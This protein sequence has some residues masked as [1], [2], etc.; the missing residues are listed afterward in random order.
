MKHLLS[1]LLGITLLISGCRN[2]TSSEPQKTVPAGK[3]FS[4][5][6][7]TVQ[8][9]VVT[10]KPSS[11]AAGTKIILQVS[12]QAGY[13][14]IK[15]SLKVKSSTGEITLYGNVRTFILPSGNVTVTGNFE[16]LP[17]NT[18]SLSVAAGD[19]KHGAI[20][21]S[22]EYYAEGDKVFLAII[23]DEGYRY[24]PGSL[25][26]GGVVFNEVTR[27]LVMP[28]NNVTVDAD[29]EPVAAGNYTVRVDSTINGRIIANP[30]EGPEGTNIYLQVIASPGYVLKTGTLKYQGPGGD[31]IINESLSTATMP[32]GHIFISGEFEKL[33]ANTYSIGIE[34]LAHGRIF[35]E[36]KYGTAGSKIT[37]QIYPDQGYAFKPG[38]LK[39]QTST[40]VTEITGADRIFEMPGDNIM[41]L[42]EFVPANQDIVKVQAGNYNNGKITAVPDQGKKDT[43]I[44]L[45]IKPDAGYQLKPGSLQYVDST[46]HETAIGGNGVFL[47]P[48][49][50]VKIKAEFESIPADIYTIQSRETVNGHV[51]SM[52]G[53]GKE[54][55]PV[56]LWVMP[57][58]GYYYKKQTLKYKLVPSNVEFSISDET[59]TFKLNA[60]HVQVR[61]EFVKTPNGSFTIRTVPAEHGMIYPRQD[62]GNSGQRIEMVIRP[63]SG[64]QIKPGSLKYQDDN[65]NIVKFNGTE[66]G[67]Y[68]PRDHVSVSGEFEAIKYTINADTAMKDGSITIDPPQGTIGAL[69]KLK[70]TPKN[71]YRLTENSLKYRIVRNNTET[72]INEQTREFFMPPENILILAK[73]EPYSALGDLKINN[74]EVKGLAGG[75]TDYTIWIP[76]NENSAKI[77]FTTGKDITVSP[78]SGETVT[79][80]AL[81]KKQAV[82]TLNSQGGKLTT[83][84]TI[85]VIREFIPVKAV[86]GGSFQRENNVNNISLVSPFRMG[87]REVVQEEWN[88]VMGFPRGAEGKTYPAHHVS[89]Y[90]AVVFCNKLSMLEG[91]TPAYVIN[92]NT[93]PG[94]WGAI[95]TLTNNISWYVS[96]NWDVNGYR[97]PTEMEWHWAAMGADS[98]LAGV[99]NTSG[100]EQAFAGIVPNVSVGQAAWYKINSGG[101]IHPAGEKEAN[102]LGIRDMS[103]NVMEWCWDWVN[104]NYQKNYGL[105][106]KQN[107]YRGG[108][109]NTGNKMRRG[110]SYL[111]EETALVL[112]YRG[113]E[114]GAQ[115]A[116][117]TSGDPRTTDEYAGL[118]IVCYD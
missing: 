4:V 34:N 18:Y 40:G 102:A 52:P 73:F 115:T 31:Q 24:K 32:K 103:G 16:A 44:Y 46:G 62:Y 9:G 107:N 15:D 78:A 2:P 108:N 109:N 96:C 111:S 7:N 57:D 105:G 19:G 94:K 83:R 49:G 14:L 99:T 118:R 10:A 114:S 80:E 112:N 28:K 42:G 13:R 66:T 74:R 76:R 69:V 81:E 71:G 56:S 60:S 47:L 117:F 6:I 11:A 110:G 8:N 93:D 72:A 48:A 68:M 98:R 79:L 85:T 53:S 88:K 38:S 97:L 113:N 104:N 1:A 5:Q 64:Y 101:A 37:L 51:I 100:Y 89:W 21:P 95:P 63:D 33:P 92:N 90:E 27:T 75:K 70:V 26:A 25:K 91:K 67:F 55:T 58:S 77:T 41:I 17:G 50:D 20:I 106:G 29:F 45:W 36:S 59:R 30:G 116:P 82:F 54:F 39:Y 35:T 87:E 86:P 3:I 65:D 61:A 22:S 12:P 84:Y 43:T 23:P